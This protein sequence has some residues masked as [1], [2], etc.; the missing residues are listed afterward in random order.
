MQ[1]KARF[2]IY[3]LNRNNLVSLVFLYCKES[4]SDVLINVVRKPMHYAYNINKKQAILERI[5]S[6]F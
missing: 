4:V 3:E 5:R 2:Y 1:L 6:E